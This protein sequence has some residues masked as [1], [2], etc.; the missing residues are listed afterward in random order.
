MRLRRTDAPGVEVASGEELDRELD[1]LLAGPAVREPLI[2]HLIGESGALGFGL[3][4]AGDGLVLFAPHDRCLPPLHGRAGGG[5][6]VADELSYSVKGRRYHFA[7]ACRLP[8]GD[9]PPRGATPPDH[10]RTARLGRV[11]TRAAARRSRRRR[12]CR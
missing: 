3:G 12:R 11:G 4:P 6:T 1:A 5:A 8:A 10:G 7:A 2:A 9:G